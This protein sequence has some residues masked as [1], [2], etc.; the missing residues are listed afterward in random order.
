MRFQISPDRQSPGSPNSQAGRTIWKGSL[1]SSPGVSKQNGSWK[2]V[3]VR[4]A[5]EHNVDVI[6]MPTRGCGLLRIP[7]TG[8]VTAKVLRAARAPVY[9]AV[10]ESKSRTFANNSHGRM[11]CAVGG[12][13][14]SVSLLHSVDAIGKE[15][16][17]D[18][19][20]VYTLISAGPADASD[21][22]DAG[23]LLFRTAR[24]RLR[25]LQEGQAP[26]STFA[27]RLA[28][29]PTLVRE[30]AVHHKVDLIVTGRKK[31]PAEVGYLRSCAYGIIRHAP[32]AVLSI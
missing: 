21:L 26:N 6:A 20:L 9:T 1:R 31:V 16:G 14:E 23:S 15:L 12:D 25:R 28:T 2:K 22:A 29:L 32:C 13:G 7:L 5:Q 24:E 19:L 17:G 11:I 30:V 3:I 27:C 8:S 18:V 10:D 4:F